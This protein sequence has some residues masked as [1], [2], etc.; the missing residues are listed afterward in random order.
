MYNI[1]AGGT[2][3]L[4]LEQILKIVQ[5]VQSH[6]RQAKQHIRQT[7]PEAQRPQGIDSLI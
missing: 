5:I 2:T 6:A 7:L 4:R 1:G 3:F